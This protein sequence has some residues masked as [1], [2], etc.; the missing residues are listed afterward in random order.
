MSAAPDPTAAATPEQLKRSAELSK[1]EAEYPAVVGERYELQELIA[2]GGMGTVHKAWDRTFQRVVAIKLIHGSTENLQ[3]LARFR[4]EALI[5]GQLQHPNIPPVYDLGTYG[6][7]KPFLAMK[8]VKGRTLADHIKHP[9]PDTPDLIAVFENVCH[10]VGYAHSRRVVHRDLKPLNVMVGAFGEVQVMDWGLAKVLTGEEHQ[11]PDRRAYDPDATLSQRTKI[12]DD[13]S[14]DRSRTTAGT[15]LGT[16]SYMPP[17][18]AI[19]AIDQITER[20]DVFGLGAIL[21]AI[22]TGKPVFV[23]TDSESTR[24]MAAR[25]ETAEAFKRLDASGAEHELIVLTKKCL[26]A[27]PHNRPENGAAVARRTREI[28]QEIEIKAKTLEIA[29]AR[30]D[31]ERKQLQIAEEQISFLLNLM[32]PEHPAPPAA[33]GNL[34]WKIVKIAESALI[35]GNVQLAHLWFRKANSIVQS[36]EADAKNINALRDLSISFERLGDMSLKQG[37]AQEARAFFDQDI[38]VRRRLAEADPQNYQ[39]QR[40]QIIGLFK[41]GAVTLLLD[42]SQEALRYF[43]Q[44]L[45]INRHL[46][47]A[48][49]MNTEIQRDLSMSY[50][51]LGDV[52]LRLG[53]T[54]EALV[55]YEQSHTVCRRLAHVDP[56][57]DEIQRDLSANYDKLGNVALQLG[58]TR[59]AAEFYEERL[60]IAFQLAQNTTINSWAQRDLCVSY[61][62][63]GDVTIRLGQTKEALEY[64]E[65][66]HA[67]RR[68]LADDEPKNVKRLRDLSASFNKLGDV[69]FRLGRTKEALAHYE[70]SL[71]VLCHISD[72]DPKNVGLLRDLI[73]RYDLLGDMYLQLDQTNKAQTYF[74][75]GLA[76]CLRLDDADPTK[77]ETKRNISI[78]HERLGDVALVLGQTKIAQAYY[79]QSHAVS[80]CLADA[81]PANTETQR[82]LGVG[83]EKLGEVSLRLGD[84]KAAVVFHNQGLAVRRRLAAADPKNAVAQRAL[85]ISYC[86]IGTAALRMG[87]V[88]AA[89]AHFEQSLAV[90]RR[91]AEADPMNAQAQMDL[92]AIC[93]RLGAVHQAATDYA[94]A[95]SWLLRA[96]ECLTRFRANGWITNTE[97]MIGTW[98]LRQWSDDIERR[99]DTCRCAETAMCDIE[100]IFHRPSKSCPE[101]LALRVSALLKRD[102]PAEAVRTAERFV[103][104]AET[105]QENRDGQRYNAACCFALCAAA[106]EKDRET[107]IDRSLDLLRKAKAGGYFTAENIAHIQQDSDFDGIRTHPKFVAFLKE[108]ET[109]REAA[110]TP[111]ERVDK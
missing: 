31:A 58:N 64:F 43:E 102:K 84:T 90:L 93:H 76:I 78:S 88:N 17:E 6:D 51:R 62:K 60:I 81:D 101:L 83:F 21:C 79:E 20:S 38:L 109:P 111:R 49:P 18:Q 98:R 26:D 55:F 39:F 92:F 10:A 94:E 91:L 41:L 50:E 2:K 108:L 37:Q 33:D 61:E 85:G 67:I 46:A 14:M 44:G 99:S 110:P 48:Y 23:G 87:D 15:I 107:L 56:T 104:W 75:R 5:S 89:R 4:H 16:P 30:A 69:N 95:L 100:S 59:A 73:T 29:N 36:V 35:R 7:N 57:N 77:V 42:Q 66:S 106:I 8:L 65:Q 52:T 24:Q 96:N 86:N 82:D 12:C 68:R 11:P 45:E 32:D 47:D 71:S 22:L 72:A 53:H 13:D 1:R 34:Y 27:N 54:K 74:E 19:G 80:R 105:V 70:Q 103:R 9:G 63:L 40:N 97:Q 25:V 3:A 28:R